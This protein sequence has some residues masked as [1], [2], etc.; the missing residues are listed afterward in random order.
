MLSKQRFC[1]KFNDSIWILEYL[2][3]KNVSNNSLSF[4]NVKC[5]KITDNC[6][7]LIPYVDTNSI[8]NITYTIQV[9]ILII[10]FVKQN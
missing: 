1:A 5:L 10:K 6:Q 3:T 9:F 2:Y 4:K 7:T 8:N